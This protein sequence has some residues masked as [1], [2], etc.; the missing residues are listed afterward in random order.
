MT[1]LDT[2]RDET[3]L[4]Y[5]VRTSVY[6][7]RRHVDPSI[8]CISLSVEILNADCS[9]ETGPVA[10]HVIDTAVPGWILNTSTL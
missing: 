10:S 6:E 4:L 5:I 1:K 3:C 8:A 7:D 9:E 2:C